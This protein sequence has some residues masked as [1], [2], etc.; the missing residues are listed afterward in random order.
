MAAAKGHP[1]ALY[2]LGILYAKGLGV[3]QDYKKAVEYFFEADKQGD[4]NAV[5]FL[6]FL[7][8]TGKGFDQTPEDSFKWFLFLAKKIRLNL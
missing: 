3:D 4:P 8:G 1:T 2:N 6:S 5:T 7:F